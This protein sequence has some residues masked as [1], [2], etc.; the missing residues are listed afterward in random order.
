MPPHAARSIPQRETTQPF[1]TAVPRQSDIRE[2][3]PRSSYRPSAPSVPP[4]A[5]VPLAAVVR[6]SIPPAA[7]PKRD[8]EE[9]GTRPIARRP[10]VPPPAPRPDPTPVTS[11]SAPP[12]VPKS[13]RQ[14][15]LTTLETVELPLEEID[16]DEAYKV[17]LAAIGIRRS[18][19]PAPLARVAN[20]V[21]ESLA[22]EGRAEAKREL[23]RMKRSIFLG[24]AM[25][26]YRVA[27]FLEARA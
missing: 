22:P 17:D 26:L 21:R 1:G 23:V 8:A 14:P 27:N 18:I 4:K 24:T 25:F 12:P 2:I 16:Y 10:T 3:K 6:K 20:D 5:A 13:A 19:L 9:S 15:V 7:A 11:K